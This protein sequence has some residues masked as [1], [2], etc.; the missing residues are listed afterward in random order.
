MIFCIYLGKT[1]QRKIE[2]HK[3]AEKNV[4]GVLGYVEMPS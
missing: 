2:T 1:Y 4:M 3:C